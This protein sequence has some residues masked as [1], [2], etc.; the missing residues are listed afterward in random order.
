MTIESGQVSAASEQATGNS[1]TTQQVNSSQTVTQED[2]RRFQSIKDKEVAE[3]RRIAEAAQKRAEEAELKMENLIQDPAVKAQLQSE[4]LHAQ[5]DHYKAREEMDKQRRWFAD[6]YGVPINVLEEAKD[7]GE[8]TLLAL[9]W[10]KEQVAAAAVAAAKA[11]KEDEVEQTEASGGHTVSLAPGTEP[12]R[13]R[14]NSDQ[15]DSQILSLRATAR[16]RGPEAQ[17]ARIAILDLE[18]QRQQGMSSKPRV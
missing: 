10:Q 8:V 18:R 13:Q 4:R 17:R 16:T 5:L 12:T 3:A 6:S 15:I 14:L 1:G 11:K 9:N 2:L 7:P